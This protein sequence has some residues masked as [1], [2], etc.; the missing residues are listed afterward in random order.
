MIRKE[1]MLRELKRKS[2]HM[3]PG[4]LAMPIIYG[5]GKY[6]A[7][8]IA[9]LFLIIYT[10]HELSLKGIINIK[11]PIASQT[12]RI[13]ARE[14]ELKGRFFTGT[15]YFWSSTLLI[16]L[17]FPETVSTAAIMV[18]S[19]GDAMA[20]IIGRGLGNIR[21]PYCKR[22]SVE[23]TVAMFITS[24]VCILLQGY[25]ITIAIISALISTFMETLP[26]HYTLDEIT[27]PWSAALVLYSLSMLPFL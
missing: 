20:A 1:L 3:I 11:V 23:G 9:L 26:I 15:I 25:N 7:A 6:I 16:I 27:V 24:L 10:L 14:E 13:M 21:I 22:K 2:I 17:I 18:S 4:F 8:L 5:L 12:F 19:L